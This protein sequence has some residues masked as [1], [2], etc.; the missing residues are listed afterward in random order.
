MRDDVLKTISSAT[1]VANAIVLTHN[2]D[3]VFIQTVVLAAFRRC[4]NPTLTIFADA[5][6][7]AESFAHQKR[8]LTGLGVRYRVVPVAMEPGFRFHPKAV[9]LSGEKAG[10]LLVG[11]GNLTFGGWRENAEVWV[12]FDSEQD[13]VAPFRAFNDYLTEILARV[14]LAK[15]IAAEV[16]EAFA[17]ESKPWVSAEP[18]GDA[19]LVGRVGSGNSLLDQMFGAVGDDPVEE[20]MV[21]APYFDDDGV[22]LRDLVTRAGA[23][24][25]RVLCQPAR[26]TLTRRSWKASADSAELQRADFMRRNASGEERSAFMHAKL[27]AFRRGHEVIVLAGSANCS[28]AA[29][30]IS[31]KAGNAELQ[32][33]RIVTPREFEEEFLDELNVTSEQVE[34]RDER[35]AD[36]DDELSAAATLRILAVRF[37]A[38][39][40]FVAYTPPSAEVLEC[41]ID[42]APTQFTIPEK[43][44]VRAVSSEKPGVLVL[45]ARVDGQIV[46]AA[47]A[48]VD[49]EYYLRATAR[50]RSLA[51]SIRARIQPGEWNASGWAEVLNLFCKHLSHTPERRVG[52]VAAGGEVGERPVGE[53]KFTAAD[54]FSPDYCTPSLRSTGFQGMIDG[55]GHVQALQQLL[56]RWF[57]IPIEGAEDESE[58]S[59]WAGEVGDENDDTVDRPEL[60]AAPPP[61][62]PPSAVEVSERDKRRIETLLR[63][64][65]EAMTSTDFLEERG[66]ADFAADLK[67]ASALLRLGLREGWVERERFFDL[68]HKVWS[69]LFFSSEPQKDV[70]WLEYRASTAEDEDTFVDEMRSAELSAALM[71]WK[72]A[73]ARENATPE[74]ARLELAAVL[75]VA[76]LPWLWHGGHPEKIAEELAL[77][78]SHTAD[79]GAN[80]DTCLREA[81]A[82]WA[83]LMRRGQAL[84]LLEDAVSCMTPEKLRDRIHIDELK[85]GDVLWQ[86]RSGFCVALEQA[87]RAVDDYVTVL[88]LQGVGNEKQ[89]KASYTIPMQAF[90]T[91]EIIPRSDA[92]GHEPRQVLSE[93]VNEL[94]RGFAPHEKPRTPDRGIR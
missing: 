83:L 21:C 24:R 32:A 42:E 74:V 23:H 46:D 1:N 50:G 35:V 3:F 58:A 17:P 7:A 22:G 85:P 54:V 5:A 93:F 33:I 31:G 39:T 66:P 4:G 12:G 64:L 44:I 90:V 16:E 27:Y 76:R 49:D 37:E 63:Q 11:S 25:S 73:A 41:L 84:R 89:F 77:L 18:T 45:R 9:L 70:G 88:P 43:G 48:W 36:A 55:G 68:T 20:L 47:P 29:L 62:K 28:R 53:S 67:V 60:L 52:R 57:G 92:F 19:R 86:G 82:E 2:I 10:T 15:P 72:L 69:S 87:S 59:G 26:T 13:G 78:L 40:L 14:P 8:I 71:G 80:Q 34:L 61:S 91:E 30:T 56:L 81:E 38:R 65:E 75:A 6:C 51:D 94:A 79:P